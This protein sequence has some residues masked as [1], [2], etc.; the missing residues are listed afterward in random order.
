MR[1]L[2]LSLLAGAAL[3]AACGD[4][5]A[6]DEETM[7][8]V[9]DA[10]VSVMMPPNGSLVSRSGSTDALQIRFSTGVGADAVAS[11]YRRQFENEGWRLV[12]DQTD[13]AGVVSMYVEWREGGRP[14][15]VRVTPEG[16]GTVV[17]LTGAVPA[18]DSA[19][20]ARRR[21][22][23]DSANQLTPRE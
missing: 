17:D 2:L 8:S 11:F 14:M 20:V 16:N 18:G 1:Q 13:S 4:R 15:W 3:V 5:S 10:F 9:T 23:A 19:Y 22:A 21:A 12:S 6:S 7:P